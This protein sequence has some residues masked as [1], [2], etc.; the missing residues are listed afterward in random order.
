LILKSFEIFSKNIDF[1]NINFNEYFKN[2]STKTLINTEFHD[3]WDC[4]EIANNKED[5]QE[6][7]ELNFLK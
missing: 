6:T 3:I 7:F 5:F 2:I 1:K 4:I